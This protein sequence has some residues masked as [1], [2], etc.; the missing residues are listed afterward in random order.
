M[1]I[2]NLVALFSFFILAGC[3]SDSDSDSFE[4]EPIN[5]I[6][7]DSGF[8]SLSQESPKRLTVL[9]NQADL[10]QIWPSISSLPTPTIGTSTIFIAEMATRPGIGVAE[11]VVESI[12]ENTDYAEVVITSFV[13]G[14]DCA[15]DA[16]L[17]TPFD[18]VQFDAAQLVLF[19]ERLEIVDCEF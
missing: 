10:D 11:I 16:A 7:L 12:V 13:P 4:E 1:L 8:N 3:S 17:S 5:F 6:R 2:R 14:P 9:R 18:A 19:R 15:V